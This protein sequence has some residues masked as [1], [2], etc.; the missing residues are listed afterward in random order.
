MHNTPFFPII[1]LKVG[2]EI[3]RILG[4]QSPGN[5]DFY[6]YIFSVVTKNSA[7]DFDPEY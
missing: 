1:L 3:I 6:I 5:C 4:L 2:G 7:R